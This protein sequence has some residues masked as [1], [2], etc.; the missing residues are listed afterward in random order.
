MGYDFFTDRVNCMVPKYNI[1]SKDFIHS[2]C[3]ISGLY[4]FDEMRYMLDKSGYY[5]I[6]NRVDLDGLHKVTGDLCQTRDQ[7]GWNTDCVTMTR[8]YYLQY[9]WMPFYIASLAVLFYLPYV[10]F[11][12]AN[13]DLVS[14]KKAVKSL[15]LDTELIVRNY[16]NYSINSLSQLRLRIWWNVCVKTLYVLLSVSSF[17][18]TDYLLNGKYLTYGRDFIDWS[19]QNNTMKHNLVKKRHRAKAGN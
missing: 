3:W 6:P 13:T 19:D 12:F 18:M 17:F 8:M 14:L 9:Q 10:V 15:S 2:A 5:G 11:L 4:I 1:L 16:F 7:S